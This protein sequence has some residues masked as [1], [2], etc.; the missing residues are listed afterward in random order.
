MEPIVGEKWP[1]RVEGRETAGSFLSEWVGGFLEGGGPFNF[2]MR[3]S[4]GMKYCS[5]YLVC[6]SSEMR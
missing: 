4:E 2:V 1:I 6:L 3:H 5:K